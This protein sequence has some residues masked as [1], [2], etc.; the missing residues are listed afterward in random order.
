M[1]MRPLT[2]VSYLIFLLFTIACEDPLE[3]DISPQ[4]TQVGDFKYTSATHWV[5]L[6]NTENKPDGNHLIGINPDTQ[7]K[8]YVRIIDGVVID[9]WGTSSNFIG[10]TNLYPSTSTHNFDLSDRI[11]P[12]EGQPKS[13]V[14]PQLTGC[15][16]DVFCHPDPQTFQNSCIHVK[17]Q[18]SS[19]ACIPWEGEIIVYIPLSL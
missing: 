18:K 1:K 2:I 4:H 5:F 19:K 6:Y 7:S 8:I 16:Y 10:I 9:A 11:D 13:S 15:P 12:I 14:L 17:Q 3:G